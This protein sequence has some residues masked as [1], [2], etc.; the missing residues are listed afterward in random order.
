[1]PLV[2]VGRGIA[3]TRLHYDRAGAGEPLLWITGFA[4]S[5]EIF[6]AG[7]AAY[8]AD[9]DCIRFDNRGSGR[10]QAPWR[11]TSIAELAGDAVALLDALGIASA[12]VYGLSMGGMV[13]QEMAIRFPDR[14]RAL[15]LG[16]TTPGGPRAVLPSAGVVAAVAA[17][18]ATRGTAAAR[19]AGVRVDLRADVLAAALFSP[20]FRA[21]QP[22][23]VATALGLLGR[24]RA[25]GRGVAA[26]W[27]SS[28][29][30]DTGARL[31]RIS[32]PTL[33]LH[34][35]A[36]Q[37]TPVANARILAARIST[38]TLRV[39]PD[40]GHVYLVEQPEAAHRLL[41]SW[42]RERSP[43]AAGV[44]LAGL[45]AR[46]E[47]VTRALGLPVGAWRTG[48][49]L[50]TLPAAYVGRAMRPASGRSRRTRA[51]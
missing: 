14:V 37:L 34:G 9:F 43:V 48:R 29:V 13:A 30:H 42:L 25:T 19:P 7:L 23:Q 40:A 51:G 32:A 49:S 27:W 10:S 26:H 45:A 5:S 20:A 31:P 35:G 47:P 24:H 28:V 22:G 18:V 6:T 12:H 44:P 38:A 46:T 21:A 41:T 50:A 33:V 11:P 4:I 17:A 39:L 36:D 15:I 8:T 3:A 2:A 16:A 1:V